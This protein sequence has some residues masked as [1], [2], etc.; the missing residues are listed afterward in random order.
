MHDVQGHLAVIQ[1]GTFMP[2]FSS[3]AD[4]LGRE[5]GRLAHH[6]HRPLPK[7][8]CDALSP[9]A[10]EPACSSSHRE[11][12]RGIGQLEDRHA[13]L[14][15]LDR[16]AGEGLDAIDSFGIVA[17]LGDRVVAQKVDSGG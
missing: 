7:G 12:D 14:G 3:S 5:L 10:A 15:P 6:D 17:A 16:R 11:I 9:P 1:P 4:D 2:N 8:E 13:P